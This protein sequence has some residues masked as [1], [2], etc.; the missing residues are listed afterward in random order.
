MRAWISPSCLP[1]TALGELDERAFELGEARSG[2]LYIPLDLA[3]ER[4]VLGRLLGADLL[5]EDLGNLLGHAARG[6]FRL[7]ARGGKIGA[8]LRRAPG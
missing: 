8:D 1:D 3:Q 6:R 2:A 4:L 5:V 7:V